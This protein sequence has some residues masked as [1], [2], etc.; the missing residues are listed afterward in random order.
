MFQ[1]D[2]NAA[3]SVIGGGNRINESGIYDGVI[4]R[5]EWTKS[6]SSSAEFL[7]IDFKSD[8]GRE[9]NY[10]SICYKKGDGSNSFG[11]NTL[12][13]LMACA[14]LRGVTS[15]NHGGKD[16]CPELTNAQITIALQA[17]GDWFQD[18]ET[19]EWKPTTNMHIYVP[20]TKDTKQ[21]AKELLDGIS[22]DTYGKLT[23]TDRKGKDKPVSGGYSE[24]QN[25]MPQNSAPQ[26]NEPPMDFDDEI[27]F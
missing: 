9:A 16:I 23:I 17:E 1:L 3:K 11:W 12:N 7:N 19:G 4:T 13:A 27:P 6:P 21:T 25:S 8:D 24:P 22:G 5:A 10:M 15:V 14:K 26:Y 20:F 2:T 18:K